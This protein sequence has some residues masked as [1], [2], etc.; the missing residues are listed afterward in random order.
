MP[1]GVVPDEGR[2]FA[3]KDS[4]LRSR[5]LARLEL[6]YRRSG[7]SGADENSK[8]FLFHRDTRAGR[9]PHC[10]ATGG[11]GI[12][13][14]GASVAPETCGQVKPLKLSITVCEYWICLE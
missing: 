5:V 4:R 3:I 6:V 1:T 12:G 10:Q 7:V 2:I 13:W 8:P 14:E 9:P 11:I